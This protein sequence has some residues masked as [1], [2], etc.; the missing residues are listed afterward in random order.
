MRRVLFVA[1]LAAGLLTAA[2]TSAVAP[3]RTPG[4]LVVAL[5]LPAQGFQVGAVRGSEV[6]YA[7]GFEIDLAR[8]IANRLGIPVIRFVSVT[9]TARLFASGAKPWDIALAQIVSTARRGRA[10]DLSVPY[11]RVDQAVLLRRGL[12]RPRALTDLA[13]LRLCALR[14]SRGADVIVSRIRPRV[15]QLLAR[16]AEELLRWVQTGRCDA[17]LHEAPTLAALLRGIR[18]RFG[19]LAGR[20]ETEAAYVVALPK[21]SPLTPEVNRVVVA[22]RRDGTVSRLARRS[23]AFDPNRLRVLS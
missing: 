1:L 20:V 16:T 19:P 7:R 10:V 3:T 6:T 4:T 9:D 14:G 8:M 12:D 23:L 11:L 18:G 21:G 17:A 13:S 22:L 2:A 15:R 5:S